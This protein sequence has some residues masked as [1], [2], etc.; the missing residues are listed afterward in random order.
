MVWAIGDIHGCFKSFKRVLKRV[1]FNP[2]RD[3]LWIVG[4]IVNR[5]E[6]SLETLEYIYSIRNSVKMVLG[7]HDIALIASYFGIKK[8]NPT[9]EPILSHKMAKEWIGWLREQPFVIHDKSLN[10]VM[11]HAGIAP[12]FSI[13]EA[14]TWN[15]ILQSRLKGKDAPKWLKGMM[16]RK[17][18]ILKY[19]NDKEYYALSSFIR[20]RYCLNHK[21][22]E[23]KNKLEPSKESYK[24]GLKPWFEVESRK[25]IDAKIVF[26]HWS[27][28]GY[29]ENRDVVCL[30]SGCLWGA[31][32]S[33]KMLNG[34]NGVVV[35]S[36]CGG[37]R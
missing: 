3:K 13:D 1:K 7:N 19:E 25:N 27:T 9:I 12:N 18:D 2:K 22:I 31:K 11:V 8:P 34:V 4:D 21:T 10:Y 24:E 36:G 26:G 28:L 17:I 15:T 30:D 16:S 5:G 33:L 20:M 14:L 37:E 35:Q 29:F 23:F 32:L 6:N